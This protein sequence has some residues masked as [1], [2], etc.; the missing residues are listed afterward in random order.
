[1]PPTLLAPGICIGNV[2]KIRENVLSIARC[3]KKLRFVALCGI[4]AAL[5]ACKTFPQG[6][7]TIYL[8]FWEIWHPTT[9]AHFDT[10]FVCFFCV[11]KSLLSFMPEANCDRQND[12]T[13]QRMTSWFSWNTDFDILFTSQ[14]LVFHVKPTFS[15]ACIIN[16]FLCIQHV[17][18]C[19]FIYIYIY[20]YWFLYVSMCYIFFWCV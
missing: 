5:D 3:P 6:V 19:V 8:W 12:Q 7:G 10:R 1:M 16:L 14:I 13:D 2:H 17:Y 15:I 9:N 20:I 18:V 4:W 11:F